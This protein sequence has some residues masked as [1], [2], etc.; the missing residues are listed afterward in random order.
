MRVSAFIFSAAIVLA[1]GASCAGPDLSAGTWRCESHADCGSGYQCEPFA[2]YCVPGLREVDGVFPDRLVFGMSAAVESGVPLADV[3]KA[4]VAGIRACFEHYNS[5]GGVHGRRLELEVRNDGYDA[6]KTATNVQELIGGADRKAFALMGVI[7]TAPSLAARKIALARKVL[8]FG[9]ATGFDGFEPDPPDRYVFNVRPRY[10]DEAAQLTRYLL[11]ATKP[12]IP[13]G[14][15]AVFAQGSDDK[16]TMDAFGGS[17]FTGVAATLAREGIADT[18]IV[19]VTY[20]TSATQNV[21]RAAS[22]LLG[23][24]GDPAR[25]E[26]AGRIPVGIVMVALVDSAVALILELEDSLAAARKGLQPNEQKYGVLSAEVLE[27]LARVDLQLTSLSTVDLGLATELKSHGRLETLDTKGKALSRA[28]GQGL[29][30]ALPVPPLTSSASGVVQ[31]QEHM[32]LH[33]PNVTPGFVSLEAYI[34]ASLL[35]RG[36]DRHG[37]DLTT[38]SLIGTLE[39]LEVDFGIG[40]TLRYSANSHQASDKLWGAQLGGDW[41]FASIG[42]LVE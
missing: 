33:Q 38:E 41:E 7:G 18:A 22:T 6:A 20:A 42:V 11:A 31:F 5:R 10:S 36:L 29:V 9:P 30:M 14:N 28:Y 26:V 13:A 39:E 32:R 8:F 23:W 34:A 27:R 19:R 15:I 24:M 3:G 25:K 17:A 1:I 40:T 4:A 35:V 16:G 12:Q 2:G 21:T 37:P